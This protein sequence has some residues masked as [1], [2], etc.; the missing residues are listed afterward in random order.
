MRGAVAGDVDIAA[1]HIFQLHVGQLREHPAHAAGHAGAQAGR[2]QRG[3]IGLAAEQQAVVAAEAEVI[4]RPVHVGHGH[5]VADQRFG[6]FGTQRLGRADVGADRHHPGFQFR[7]DVLQPGV[8]GQH[9]EVRI[10]AALRGDQ[11]RLRPALH[12]DHRGMLMDDDAGRFGSPR[13]PLRIGQRMQVAAGGV[14]HRAEVTVAGQFLLQARAVPP[15][16]RVVVAL[17]HAFDVRTQRAFLTRMDRHAGVAVVPVAVD[18]VTGDALFELVHAITREIEQQPR[19][20]IADQFFQRVLLAAITDDGLAAI[21]TGSAPTDALGFQH[22]DLVALF[23]QRQRSGQAGVTGTQHRNVGTGRTVQRRAR[24]QCRLAAGVP[25]G[26]VGGLW[27][28]HGHQ[29]EGFGRGAGS[30]TAGV[31]APSA[32]SGRTVPIVPRGV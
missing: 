12:P 10:N 8:A 5:V 19:I 4:Q 24:R 1:P 26:W 29:A 15:F 3:I 7:C 22:G 32:G 31:C 16:Q 21:A 11:C 6:A 25:T 18:G 2:R 28:V 27:A 9:H 20:G 17:R 14:V 13:Q 30:V 23:G